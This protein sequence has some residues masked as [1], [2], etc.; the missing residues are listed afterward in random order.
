[1]HTAPTEK[2]YLGVK[3]K[4]S[5]FCSSNKAFPLADRTSKKTLCKVKERKN[6]AQ[7]EALTC[8]SFM[9]DRTCRPKIHISWF[10]DNNRPSTYQ[11]D[12]P[13]EK[14]CGQQRERMIV[15]VLCK[16]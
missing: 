5:W 13:T 15:L 3:G 8:K 2:Q 11:A 10:L 6:F 1:M 12:A 4:C 16:H 9:A 14:I 7:A